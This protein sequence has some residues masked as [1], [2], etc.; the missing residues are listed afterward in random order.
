MSSRRWWR[1]ALT[2]GR[3]LGSTRGNGSA[4]WAWS[5]RRTGPSAP[6]HDRPPPRHRTGKA[7]R[8]Y[9]DVLSW[10]V[11]AIECSSVC[12]FVLLCGI[13]S[14]SQVIR[15][16]VPFYTVNLQLSCNSW[17]C[18]CNDGGC[19]RTYCRSMQQR[20]LTKNAAVAQVVLLV[21]CK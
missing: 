7:R 16:H 12:L 15:F 20:V 6:R 21:T 4:T 19:A 2:G 3:P 10:S 9:A 17:V 1:P 8:P 14:V 5:S 11:V 13:W 18:D